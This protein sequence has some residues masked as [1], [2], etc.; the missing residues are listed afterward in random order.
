M[1]IDPL[2]RDYNEHG[3][4]VA[5]CDI[6]RVRMDYHRRRLMQEYHY[7][8]VPMYLAADYEHMLHETKPDVVI[9][10]T[11][12]S[13]HHEYIIRALHAG[14]DVVTEKPMTTD[15]EKCR[16]IS[17]AVE[18][19]QRNVRVTFNGRWQPGTGKV[20]ELIQSKIIGDIK[21]V[22]LEYLLDT[23]HGAD[24]FRRWH[25]TKAYSGG[26]L[27]H[28]STHHFDFV[29]WWLDAIPEEVFAYGSLGFYGKANAISRGDASLTHYERYSDMNEAQTDPFA[30]RLDEASLQVLYR[31]AEDETGYIR[32]RNVFRDGIDIEDTMA[33][34][35]RY[36]TGAI[37]TYSLV[38]YS[39][40]E[41]FRASFTGDRGRLEY[42]ELYH[43][44]IIRGQGDAELSR[45]HA[46]A[47][48]PHISLRVLPMFHKAYEVPIQLAAG[49][50]GGGD[51][52]LQ[53]QVFSPD[54]PPDSKNR[55][56]GHEQG[57]ASILIGIAANHSMGSG[58]PIK[59]NDLYPLRPDAGRLSELV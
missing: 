31:D 3:E 47:G 42:S 30:L 38:A 52:L 11:M 45:E 1:F 7:H 37:L 2:A 21:A 39:P 18:E 12:D 29:N 10:C 6:S 54:A 49:G 44:H 20:R 16:A 57:A 19:T 17:A 32:D 25:A 55:N 28:K 41:G 4:L 56:A 8:D 33:L 13:T 14:C 5:L 43:P 58:Q 24:Y 48:G 40:L 51:P 9:V 22:N 36:R 26:L 35:V 23:S 15:E 50:H 34:L 46:A 53:E 59:I 27:V